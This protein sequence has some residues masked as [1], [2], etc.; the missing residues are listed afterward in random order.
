MQLAIAVIGKNIPEITVD[1]MHVISDCQCNVLECRITVLGREYA[2]HALV[3][4]NW[5]HIA[6]L[7]NVLDTL[8]ARHQLK[9]NTCRTEERKPEAARIPYTID[10]ITV[11]RMAIAEEVTSF[12][13]D[14]NIHIHEFAASRYPAPHTGSHVFAM[15]LIVSIPTN[16]PLVTLRDEFLEFCDGLTIDAILEPV[17]R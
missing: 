10:A 11:D 7:E 13:Q 14:R 9:I 15:H 4:G 17:K 16:V 12:L 5:N 6:K 3:E 1:L 8:A 2:A